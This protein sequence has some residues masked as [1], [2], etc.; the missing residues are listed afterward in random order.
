MIG[1]VGNRCTMLCVWSATKR[2]LL[3]IQYYI[4]RE[5]LKFYCIFSLF[6]LPLFG[7][8]CP[9]AS[10]RSDLDLF[11]SR[12]VHVCCMRMH[13]VQCPPMSSQYYRLVFGVNFFSGKVPNGQRREAFRFNL[14]MQRRAVLFAVAA[15]FVLFRVVPAQRCIV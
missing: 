4:L 6:S 11:N 3:S 1:V 14:A 9:F 7:S 10:F 13:S 12:P 8:R 5:L 2:M 15:F